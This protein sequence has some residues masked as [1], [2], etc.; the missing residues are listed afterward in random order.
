M[1]VMC[2]VHWKTPTLFDHLSRSKYVVLEKNCCGIFHNQAHILYFTSQR[3]YRKM[4]VTGK[5]PHCCTIYNQIIY[6]Q[7]ITTTKI[8]MFIIVHSGVHIILMREYGHKNK[9]LKHG[10]KLKKARN[11]TKIQMKIIVGI[12]KCRKRCFQIVRHTKCSTTELIVLAQALRLACAVS[13]WEHDGLRSPS[14]HSL[15]H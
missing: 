1:K 8:F 3:Y 13:L 15:Q 14:K 2:V 11:C 9:N 4:I 6:K 10:K 12:M 7:C 5:I